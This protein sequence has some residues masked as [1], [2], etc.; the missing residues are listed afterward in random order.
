[1]AN[2]I[3]ERLMVGV[4]KH[5]SNYKFLTMKRGHGKGYLFASD[6]LHYTGYNAVDNPRDSIVAFERDA[7]DKVRFYDNVPTEGFQIEGYK[8][9]KHSSCVKIKDPRGFSTYVLIHNFCQLLANG[10]NVNNSYLQGKFVHS[11]TNDEMY[12]LIPVDST[13]YNLAI[14]ESDEKKKIKAIKSQPLNLEVGKVYIYCNKDGKKQRAIYMGKLPRIVGW[15][16]VKWYQSKRYPEKT[17]EQSKHVWFLLNDELYSKMNRYILQR[18]SRF[19]SFN[20]YCEMTYLTRLNRIER[21]QNPIMSC[22]LKNALSIEAMYFD[23]YFAGLGNWEFR[24]TNIVANGN[25]DKLAVN[26]LSPI[27]DYRV[28]KPNNRRLSLTG[29]PHTYGI[30]SFDYFP[31]KWSFD[32]LLKGC[33]M[34]SEDWFRSNNLQYP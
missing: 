1:M 24:I 18:E 30:D 16:T 19:A 29:R 10:I 12:N 20:G 2:Y 23:D 32:D 4:Y 9:F 31:S 27:Q 14:K 17:F 28:I 15:S 5:D 33:Y 34:I 3:P 7:T 25:I 8:V 13:S 11:I 26:G 6:F 22:P 21:I